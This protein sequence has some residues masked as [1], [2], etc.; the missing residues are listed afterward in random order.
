MLSLGPYKFSPTSLRC[1]KEQRWHAVECIGQILL[2]NIGSGVE[3]IDLEGVIYPQLHFNDLINMRESWVNQTHHILID[4]LGIIL[5]HFVI[6][7]IEEKQRFFLVC[8]EFNL[9]LKRYI[10][11]RMRF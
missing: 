9:S 5:G 7:H 8:Q 6:T 4:T 10:L 11:K 3:H 1:Y 2:Q